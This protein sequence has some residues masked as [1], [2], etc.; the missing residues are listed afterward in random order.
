M[1][2]TETIGRWGDDEFL[3]LS[4]EPTPGLLAAHAQALAGMARTSDFRWWGD[5]L[6]LSVSIGAAQ[7][8]KAETLPQFFERV[9]AAMRTSVHAGGNHITLA[10]ER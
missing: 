8:T 5:R 3:L 2:P 10:P 4:H 7:A 1:H 9:Q 6:S